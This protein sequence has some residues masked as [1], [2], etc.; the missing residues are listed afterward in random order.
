[1]ASLS[2]ITSEGNQGEEDCMKKK[3]QEIFQLKIALK[4]L[5]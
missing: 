3:Y 5:V 1:M 2:F 4:L